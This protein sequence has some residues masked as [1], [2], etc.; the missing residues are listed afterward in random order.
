MKTKLPPE[1]SVVIRKVEDVAD[2][3][4]CTFCTSSKLCEDGNETLT[5]C[6]DNLDEVSA[7]VCLEDLTDAPAQLMSAARAFRQVFPS[8]SVGWED[9]ATLNNAAVLISEH[10]P[11][12]TPA[13]P[14]APRRI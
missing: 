5:A 9:A 13:W 14:N 8:D 11:K 1:L 7:S 12:E 3:L 4:A 6:Q 2:R 10:L